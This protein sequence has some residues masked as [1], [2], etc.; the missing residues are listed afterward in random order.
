MI[1]ILLRTY[2]E[3][4]YITLTKRWIESQLNIVSTIMITSILK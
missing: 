4:T 1:N 3:T 2:Y